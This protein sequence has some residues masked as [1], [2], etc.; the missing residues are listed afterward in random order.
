[1]MVADFDYDL[2]GLPNSRQ[3]LHLFRTIIQQIGENSYHIQW[4][5]IGGG[6]SGALG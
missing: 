1:M 6:N 3:N 5:R 2:G 4:D